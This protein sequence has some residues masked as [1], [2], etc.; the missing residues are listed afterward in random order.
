MK[1]ALIAG[2]A[3]AALLAV[4]AAAQNRTREITPYIEVG[5]VLT[6][7]LDG[8]SDVLTYTNVSAGIDMS[9][10]TSRVEV[11]LNYRYDHRIDWDKPVTDG[12]VHSGLARA[13]V[14][15]G[16]GLNIEGGALAARAR[17]D[18]RG[19]APG[20]LAGNASNVSQIFGAYAGP[21]FAA[22]LD[23]T[24]VNAAYRFGYVKVEEPGIV[25]PLGAGQPRLD[26]YDS[27]TNH[28]A[29]ASV[30][31]RAGTYAPFGFTFSGAWEREDVSQLDQRY[32]GKYLRADVVMPVTGQVALVGGIGYENIEIS[33]RDPLVDATGV[34]VTTG[35]GRFVTDPASPRRLAYETDGLFWDAGVIW[36]PSVRTTVQGRV[37]RRYDTMSYTGSIAYQASHRTGLNIGVF[38]SVDSFGRGL[39]DT[40]ATLPTAFQNPI[41]PFGNQFGGCVFGAGDGDGI[42][43]N[44]GTAINAAGDCLT[45]L[46]GALTTA[47]FRSRGITGVLSTGMGPYTIGVGL[48]YANRKFLVPNAGPNSILANISDDIYFGQFTLGR[49]LS[50]RSAIAAN[51]YLNWFNPGL[52]NAPTVFG[53]GGNASYSYS[54]GRLG[55]IAS[56]GVFAYDQEQFG[57]DV[58]GQALLGMR[59]SF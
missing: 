15:L 3:G 52:P 29:T 4:P 26:S 58:S 2:V 39:S 32:D 7:D 59:Y 27:S 56:V 49:E 31:A 44:G 9:L 37:G 17:D 43:G 34:P 5:Q 24:T 55:A 53:G 57:K 36:R 1:F 50:V 21:T 16:P 48:G 8:P 51:A 12:S 28:M 42:T 10:Q 19:P 22:H 46:L 25:A 13:A 45:P 14:R 35:G 38:D 47:S 41:D 33:L 54:F 20:G 23:E 11:Q 40:L 18:I 6:A 30:G